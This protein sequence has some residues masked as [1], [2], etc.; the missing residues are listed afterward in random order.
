[1]I[2]SSRLPNNEN[3][4]SGLSF[5]ADTKPL[6]DRIKE[7]VGGKDTDSL[8][9]YSLVN[10]TVCTDSDDKQTNY[11]TIG[12]NWVNVDRSRGQL[13]NEALNQQLAALNCPCID[14]LAPRIIQI[15][16]EPFSNANRDTLLSKL[17]RSTGPVQLLILN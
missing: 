6:N 4:I 1:M 10:Q 9:N 14:E 7:L 5:R 17:K 15:D 3:L 12:R 16:G 13:D 2:R 11:S 8:A